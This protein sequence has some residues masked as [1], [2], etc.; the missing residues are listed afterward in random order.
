M[1]SGYEDVKIRF[2]P[3]IQEFV[4]IPLPNK[5]GQTETR[6]VVKAKFINPNPRNPNAPLEITICHQRK[7]R[8]G[9]FVDCKSYPLSKLPSGNEIRMILDSEQT[10]ALKVILDKLL[11]YCKEHLG[12]SVPTPTFSLENVNEIVNVPPSRKKLIQSLVN[13]NFE[14]EFWGELEKIKPGE[15][16][17]FALNKIIANRS[18][19]LKQFKIHLNADDWDEKVWQEFFEQNTW[20][21]GFGLTFKWIKPVGEKLEQTT[22]GHSISQAG[23]RPN[24]FMQTRASI[25]STVFIDIKTPHAKLLEEEYR[26]GVFLIG[27]EVTGGISQIQVTIESWIEAEGIKYMP[28][29]ESGYTENKPIYSHNPKGILVVGSLNQFKANGRYH[30]KQIASFELF[31]RNILNPEIITFDELYYRANSIL[32][33]KEKTADL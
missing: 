8:N 1:I 33:E 5:N 23:K 18:E 7:L 26:P 16:L 19:T 22:T 17:N 15:T 13:G 6:K 29:D 24:G 12:M 3:N 30:D 32:V 11:E 4:P 21:F 10:L 9:N 25:S 20:I 31:R 2:I 14:Q 27:S 28:L